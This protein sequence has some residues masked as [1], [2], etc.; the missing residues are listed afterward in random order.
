M[1]FRADRR[2]PRGSHHEHGHSRGT[3]RPG[4]PRD[5]GT[6]P[7]PEDRASGAQLQPFPH[8]RNHKHHKHHKHS[9]HHEHSEHHA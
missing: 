7:R 2:S 9:E 8:P 4:P 5:P 1:P 6:R 3:G